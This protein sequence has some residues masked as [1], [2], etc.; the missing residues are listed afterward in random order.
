MD[1]SVPHSHSN[2]PPFVSLGHGCTS[3]LGPASLGAGLPIR[4]ER[5]QRR[6][7]RTIADRV[8]YACLDK[9]DPF[10]RRLRAWT[11]CFRATDVLEMSTLAGGHIDR[12]WGRSDSA[13][14]R[15]AGLYLVCSDTEVEDD[16]VEEEDYAHCFYTSTRLHAPGTAC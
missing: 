6:C 15:Q 3:F 7:G 5:R 4:S 2:F 12:Y 13:Y 8:V 16:A 9:R 10:T 11:R 14:L 1:G